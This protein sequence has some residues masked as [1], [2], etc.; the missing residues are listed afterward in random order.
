MRQTLLR[1][2]SAPDAPNEL[3]RP[4]SGKSHPSH[5]SSELLRPTSVHSE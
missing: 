4:V 2:A 5:A 1:G 3:L